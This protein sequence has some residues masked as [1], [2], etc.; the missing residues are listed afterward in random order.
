[1]LAASLVPAAVL[2]SEPCSGVVAFTAASMAGAVAL[3]SGAVLLLSTRS[4]LLLL[5]LLGMLLRSSMASRAAARLP[6]SFVGAAAADGWV[7]LIMLGPASAAST[8]PAALSLA[9]NAAR[10]TSWPIL[11]MSARPERSTARVVDTLPLEASASAAASTVERSPLTR[12]VLVPA[13]GASLRP[14]RMEEALAR[15]SWTAAT[16]GKVLGA[17]VALVVVVLESSS[18]R[19]S[20]T[21]WEGSAAAGALVR[22]WPVEEEGSGRR[23][24]H[25]QQQGG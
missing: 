4:P 15:Y 17:G 18:L 16:A 1:M 21:G 2:L 19:R 11:L 24:V 23:G 14:D 20:M 7:V 5:V 3:T 10:T 8:G 9:P 22:S 12:V 25:G 6:A 13:T